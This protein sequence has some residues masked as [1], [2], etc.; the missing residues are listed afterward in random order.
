MKQLIIF[1]LCLSLLNAQISQL[2]PFN[3]D[4]SRLTV[5]GMS[6][7]GF[8]STQFHV[9]YSSVITGMGSWAGG[10]FA[11]YI[12][13]KFTCMNNPNTSHGGALD[14]ITEAITLST[15]LRI[16]DVTNM[17]NDKI[18]IFTGSGDSTSPSGR[19]GSG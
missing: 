8:F 17:A 9:A 7:G 1:V 5:S 18:Y 14:T 11:C 4:K 16:D 19:K 6:A 2:P 12:S 3:V 10:P 15:E 13:H